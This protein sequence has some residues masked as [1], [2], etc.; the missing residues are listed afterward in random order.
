MASRKN[1]NFVG[2]RAEGVFPKPSELA[3]LRAG[4]ALAAAP[5]IPLPAKLMQKRDTRKSDRRLVGITGATGFLGD[6]ILRRL[7]STGR[8]D[9]RALSRSPANPATTPQKV[10]WQ[11]GDL[12]SARD[13]DIFTRDL[14]AV[15]HFAHANTP[16]S[17]HRDWAADALLNL[18]PS[19]NLIEAVRRQRRCLDLVFA[20]SGGA[21]YGRRSHRAPFLESD[22][23][24][25]QSPYGIVKL[26]IESYLR[27]AVDEGWFRVSVLRIGNPYGTLLL[28]ERRQGLIGVAMNQVLRGEPVP[29]YGNPR[30]VRDYVHLSDVARIVER[31]L[32]PTWP[33][34]IYNVGSGQGA[35]TAEIVDLIEKTTRIP[36]SRREV[37]GV[38]DADRLPSWS[39]LDIA[40][41]ATALGWS[42]QVSLSEGIERLYREN[43]KP[44]NLT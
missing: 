19:L 16:L 22:P 15:I 32:E 10:V 14:D 4:G 12:S 1:C 24:H 9:F 7:V 33:F 8:Y 44:G 17:S 6:Y 21:V 34:E 3:M 20:S 5:L 41:A 25:P 13:C 29:I 26:A 28:P 2:F 39:V 23:T 43:K 11:R 36:V 40:K 31:C 35:S 30:N 38:A 42:P 18:A 37:P 27:L